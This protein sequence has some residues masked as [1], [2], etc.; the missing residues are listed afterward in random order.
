MQADWIK[1]RTDLYRDPKVIGMADHLMQSGGHLARHVSQLCQRDMTVT[2][3]VTRCA[4]VGGLVAVWGVLRHRGNRV[5]DDLLVPNCSDA[6]LDD[7][8]DVPGFGEAMCSVGWAI[9]TEDG[10]ILPKFFRDLNAE[11]IKSTGAERQKRYRERKR[12]GDVTRDDNGDVTRPVTVTGEKRERREESN[13]PRPP[14]GGSV[15]K[16]VRA[17]KPKDEHRHFAAFWTAYPRKTAK[18]AAITAFARIDPD[19]AT[20]A[21]MLAA[22]DRQRRSPD[23]CK[24]DGRFIPH[25]ATWLNQRR[26][27]DLPPEVATTPVL[28]PPVY[29]PPPLPNGTDYGPNPRTEAIRQAKLKAQQ[30]EAATSETCNG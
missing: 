24:D 18:P 29:T 7:I 14:V 6:V 19:D 10:V 28:P 22:L 13:T 5:G 11:P 16:P 20:F 26:W 2:R 12:Y 15:E 17:A 4:V 21:A 27:E 25:P 30:Q 1:M 8:A 9:E 3:N 23:W